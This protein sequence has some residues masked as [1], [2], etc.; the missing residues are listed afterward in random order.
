MAQSP[1]YD[2]QKNQNKEDISDEHLRHLTGISEDEE[3]AMD[4]EAH[5]GAAKD[6][7][8]RESP[9]ALSSKEKD[10]GFYK[11]EGDKKEEKAVDDE[12]GGGFY[13]PDP[14][15]KRRL[16]GKLSGRQKAAA[17]GGIGLI[18]ALVFGGFTFF[19]GPFQ[20]IHI[21][22]LLQRFHFQSAQ[23]DGNSRILKLYKWAKNAKTGTAENARLGVIGK[24]V[25]VGMDAKLAEIGITKNFSATGVYN[26]TE[27]DALKF[28]EN[29]PDG[30]VFKRLGEDEFIAK[31]QETYGVKLNK[32][33]VE[34]SGKFT[35]DEGFFTSYFKNRKLNKMLAHEAG[36]DNI[37]G[38]I[39]ARIMG[40]RDAVPWHPIKRVD[41]AISGKIDEQFTAWLKKLKDTIGN[42]AKEAPNATGE[43]AKDDKGRVDETQTGKNKSGA[44]SANTDI[45]QAGD[46]VQQ[47]ESDL[48]NGLKDTEAVGPGYIS[49]L[50]SSATGKI[51]LSA[52]AIIGLACAAKGIANAADNVKHDLVVLPLIRTGMQAISLG[53][54]VMNGKDLS[55]QQ[56]GFFAKEL[57]DPKS[58]SWAA[59]KSI[60]AEEGQ[61]KTGPDMPDSANPGKIGKNMFSQFLDKIYG[62]DTVCSVANSFLGG[63]AMTV[64]GVVTAPFQTISQEIISQSGVLDGPISSLVRWMAGSPIP[65]FVKGATYGNYINYGARLAANDSAAS[66]GGVKLSNAQALQIKNYEVATQQQDI[67]SESIAQRVLDPYSP[68]SLV[69]KALDSGSSNAGSNMASIFSNIVNPLKLLSVL[70][71]PFTQRASADSGNYDYGFPKVGFSLDDMNNPSYD[72]PYDNACLVSG[73]CTL[74]NGLKIAQGQSVLGRHSDYFDRAKKCFGVIIS[75]DGNDITTDFSEKIDVLKQGKDS[76]D[77]NNCADSSQDWTRVRF[78]VL[79]M[80]T[81][82]AADCFDSGDSQS[83][84]DSGFD[85]QSSGQQPGGVVGGV[86]GYKNPLR[87]VKGMVPERIDQGVDYA[88]T[89]PVYA[90]GNGTV[91]DATGSSGWPGG[92]WI[93]Y[94]LDDGPAS[95]KVVYFAE[96]CNIAVSAGQHVTPDT[97]ICNMF[98]GTSGIETGWAE[99]GFGERA[100]AHDI[101]HEGLSTAL[102]RNY[103]DLLKKLGAPPGVLTNDVSNVPLPAGWPTW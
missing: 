52:T 58:G 46:A 89:G 65:T 26:G 4:R 103:S 100:L 44:D 99:P 41:S 17:G 77:S 7:Y 50:T 83:C 39:V 60:Q 76:Y 54:Q 70:K 49:K 96:N 56:L 71:A 95:G 18:I 30:D 62:L 80:K 73:N 14:T 25:A 35:V 29:S 97:V 87:D 84:Q 57:N 81:A 23:D 98:R 43:V 40:K 94:Q 6:I 2:D 11:P 102:G 27:I 74:S 59:A 55:S 8:D 88:G 28:S 92:N 5:S 19:S 36:Y 61:P 101:Y 66:S 38:S 31:F 1:V 16:L 75:P 47:S 82:E 72:N 79:D 22:Q 9:E 15:K 20:F 68:D 34:G 3:S 64:V 85:N 67:S 37:T 63:L 90:M 33:V 91:I 53:N 45:K 12:E 13:K 86:E 32:P 93:S 69:G 10:G 24:R 78:Y 21:A 51:G 42:G 48:A